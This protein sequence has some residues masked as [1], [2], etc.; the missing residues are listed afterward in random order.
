MRLWDSGSSNAGDR[1]SQIQGVLD[2]LW[3]RTPADQ[4]VLV[5]DARWLIQLAQSP[6]TDELAAYFAVAEKMADSFGRGPA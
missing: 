4:P 1:L 3:A 5:R 2:R 6:A